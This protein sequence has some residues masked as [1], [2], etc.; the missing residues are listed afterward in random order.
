[1]KKIFLPDQS[2]QPAQSAEQ[3]TRESYVTKLQKFIQEKAEAYRTEGIPVA[4]DGR[5]D[6]RAYANLHFSEREILIDNERTADY[7]AEWFGD[8][9]EDEKKKKR[10][11][12]EGEQLEM[13]SYAIFMKNLG[14]EF[15]VVRSSSHDDRVNKVDTLILDRK[16]GTLVCAFDEVGAIN[17]YEYEEKRILVRDRN[18]SKGGATLKYGLGVENEGGKQSVVL[19]RASNIPVFYIALDS[20]SIK[21]GLKEF[22][23]QM[24]TQSE[25]EKKLFSY[26]II[27]IIAQI[28]GLELN[29]RRLN[30]ALKEKLTAFKDIMEPIQANLKKPQA[31]KKRAG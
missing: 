12:M 10:T 1:M 30:P 19:A 4:D 25:F 27:S 3:E 20:E 31:N 14:D 16:T 18:L 24:K 11:Q 15:V 29:G 13:L 22:L 23:P 17:G 26:F 7:E 2:E 9:S 6:N 8:V 21:N 28:E 5:I